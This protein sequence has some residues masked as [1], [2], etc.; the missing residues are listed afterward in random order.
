MN[1]KSWLDLVRE[2]FPDAD[3]KEADDILWEH[4]AFPF[5]G[6]EEIRKSLEAFRNSQTADPAIVVDTGII[7]SGFEVNP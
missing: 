3:D 1:E 4:T 2:Y 6:S 5:A 7:S